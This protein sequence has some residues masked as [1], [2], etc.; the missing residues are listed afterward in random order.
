MAG[1]ELGLVGAVDPHDPAA[2]PV[3]DRR[4]VAGPERPRS[5]ERVPEAPERLGDPE[6]AGRRRRAGLSGADGGLEDRSAITVERQPLGLTVHHDLH[7]RA[8]EAVE[9]APPDP[10]DAPVGPTGYPQQHP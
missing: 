4:V 1:N 2:G 5:V 10:A 8:V 7:V 3:A 6:V 9:R